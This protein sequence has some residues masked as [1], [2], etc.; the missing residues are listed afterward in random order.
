LI[1]REEILRIID[2]AY[3]AR[4]RGDKEAVAEYWE[5]DAVYRLAGE[6]SIMP[7]VPV[8]PA[9]V[10]EAV[11]ALIDLFH[12]H[13]LERVEAVVEGLNAAI[14]WRVTVSTWGGER[15]DA[16]LFDLWRFSERGKATSLLQFTDT[17]LIVQMLA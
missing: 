16:E 1:E 13:K 9:D 10:M 14:H 12:F 3:A 4:M 17:A 11:G 8:G 15:V 5:P 7:A 6:A 2:G